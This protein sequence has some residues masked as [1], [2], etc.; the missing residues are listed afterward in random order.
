MVGL[1]PL[2]AAQDLP[3]EQ[4]IKLYLFTTTPKKVVKVGVVDFKSGNYTE[5]GGPFAINCAI[6]A[7][8][9]HSSGTVVAYACRVFALR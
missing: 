4:A 9:G 5:S 1:F 6:Y 8:R 3:L 7:R 2:L